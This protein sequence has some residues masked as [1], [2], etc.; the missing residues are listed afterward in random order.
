MNRA[1]FYARRI[2]TVLALYRHID[3][4]FFRNQR[5]VV[6][7][8]GVFKI[9]K[10]SP[11]EPENPDPMEL[12]LVARIIVFFYTCIDASSAANATG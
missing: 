9:D 12:R 3:E 7:M 11:F 5:R 8:L 1:Y 6:V 2:F 4:I 10:I